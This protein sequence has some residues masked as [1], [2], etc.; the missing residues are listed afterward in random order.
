MFDNTDN[1]DNTDTIIAT[2]PECNEPI[3]DDEYVS[4]C[5]V[6]DCHV[7]CHEYDA[8]ICATHP[9]NN[10]CYRGVFFIYLTLS[11]HPRGHNGCSVKQTVTVE[12]P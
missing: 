1:T 6:K 11:P 9:C 3:Y 5:Q 7:I 8:P 4:V 10:R 12:I 2:C